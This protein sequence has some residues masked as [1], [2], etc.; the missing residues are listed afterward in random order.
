MLRL[1][2]RLGS[3]SRID[4]TDSIVETP[5]PAGSPEVTDP[6]H[7]TRRFSCATGGGVVEAE[8]HAKRYE[9]AIETSMGPSIFHRSKVRLASPTPCQSKP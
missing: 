5:G 9:F 4:S 7:V 2:G 6:G 3:M 1:V 8:S